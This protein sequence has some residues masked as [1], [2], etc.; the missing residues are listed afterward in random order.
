M[1]AKEKR[2]SGFNLSLYAKVPPILLPINSAAEKSEYMAAVIPAAV[3]K[4][5]T[6]SGL[7]PFPTPLVKAI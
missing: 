1:N 6:R 3:L 7:Y 2:F 5:A 4:N